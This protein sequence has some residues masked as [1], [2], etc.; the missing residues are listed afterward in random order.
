[1]QTRSTRRLARKMALAARSMSFR[2]VAKMF[3]IVTPEGK[4]NPGMVYRIIHQGYEPKRPD[5]IRRCPVPPVEPVIHDEP[6]RRVL[7]GAWKLDGR[8]VSPE[9]FF[10]VRS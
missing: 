4:P 9:E 5:T 2:Q 7:T 1:M 8:W 3:G 10:G 6:I